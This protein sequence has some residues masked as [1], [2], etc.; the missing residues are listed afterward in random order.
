MLLSFKSYNESHIHRPEFDEQPMTPEEAVQLLINHVGGM[1][2]ENFQFPQITEDDIKSQAFA[3]EAKRVGLNWN[4]KPMSA[5][6]LV[7]TNKIN[8]SRVLNLLKDSRWPDKPLMVLWDGES[9][10]ILEGHTLWGALWCKCQMM[11]KEQGMM[12]GKWFRYPTYIVNGSMKEVI[13]KLWQ[14]Y[15]AMQDG[16]RLQQYDMDD[17]TK[18]QLQTATADFS[19]W[20]DG[21]SV[22]PAPQ[23]APAPT[24]KEDVWARL[25]KHMTTPEEAVPPPVAYKPKFV[26]IKPPTTT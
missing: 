11:P 22:T 26:R 14:I 18:Q 4:E 21:P 2:V 15:E 13:T 17:T 23:P 6:E 9:Y 7:P 24:S 10:K 20:L 12:G 25:L 8:F 5:L 19:S 3:L 1:K 16:P